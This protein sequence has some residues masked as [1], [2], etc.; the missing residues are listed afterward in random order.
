MQTDSQ[1]DR[2]TDNLFEAHIPIHNIENTT[3]NYKIQYTASLV[4][5]F[6]LDIF[7]NSDFSYRLSHLYFSF[8]YQTMTTLFFL[9]HQAY[10]NFL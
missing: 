6:L 4:I 7:S 2:Q 5:V 8:E 9:Y 1:V 3:P 10:A